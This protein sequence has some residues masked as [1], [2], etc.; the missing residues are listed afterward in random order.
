[1][2]H[3]HTQVENLLNGSP[4]VI[5]F[6]LNIMKGLLVKYDTADAKTKPLNSIAAILFELNTLLAST[7]RSIV[8]L[9][10][11]SFLINVVISLKVFLFWI[12]SN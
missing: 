3:H 5:Y 1:M 7:N 11:F 6:F 8:C 9:N 10:A 12:V 2:L 4:L